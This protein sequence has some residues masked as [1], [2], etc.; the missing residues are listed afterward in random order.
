[1]NYILFDD[2]TWNELLP[3]TY[4]RPVSEIRVGILTIREKWERYL[5]GEPVSY[6]TRQYLSEKYPMTV[7]ADNIFV[8]GS[9]IPTA[10]LLSELESLEVGQALVC[11][12][13]VC[14]IRLDKQQAERFNPEN[15]SFKNYTQQIS[16][17]HRI[18]HLWDIFSMNGD[19]IEHDFRIVTKGRKSSQLS[20]SNRFIGNG[21]IFVEHGAVSECCIFN[22]TNGPIYIGKNSEIMEGSIIRGPFALGA[23]SVVKMGAKIYGPTTVGPHS[24]VGGEL[25]NVVIFANSNK[26]HDGFLGNAVVGEW[27]NFGADTNCSN[28]KNDYS[29]VKQW[30]YPEERFVKT[31]L[32]FCGLVMGD[33][34]KTSINTM[35]NTGTV[36]GVATNVFGDG[37]PRNFVPSFSWGGA[38]GFSECSVAKA[39]EIAER[40]MARRGVDLS[41]ADRK[42][43]ATVYDMS[44]KYR[45]AHISK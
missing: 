8:N 33:H 35:F 26:G 25:N 27:C 10:E 3:L 16:E 36:V 21:D 45:V 41:D 19:A 17:C 28:L 5:P 12:N 42:I 4:T 31:G 9:V 7:G 11:D 22:T 37:F 1:M 39:C 30:N 23:N 14:A 34:S 13:L 24:K 15:I 2:S 32:Q 29:E 43:L 44:A 38:S 40:V 18:A 6:C 20:A